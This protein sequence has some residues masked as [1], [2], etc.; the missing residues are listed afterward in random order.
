MLFDQTTHELEFLGEALQIMQTVEKY[1]L[2]L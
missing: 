2:V 1:S